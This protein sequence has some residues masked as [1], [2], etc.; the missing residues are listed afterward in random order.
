MKPSAPLAGLLLTAALAAP[1]AAV[2]L[3]YASLLSSEVPGASPGTGLTK[4]TIDTDLMT[5]RVEASFGGLLGPTTVAHIHCCTALPGLGTAGVAT[6]VPTFAGFP[7][8][9]TAGTYDNTFD[10]SLASSYNPNFV[11]AQGGVANAFSTLLG[12]FNAGTAYLNIHSSKF[13]GGEI[14]GFPTAVP[15]PETYALMVAG[16]A[17]VGWAAKRRRKQ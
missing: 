17:A 1:A 9:V 12:G 13:P 7:S 6:Q 15:E 14:R 4:L 5:M 2:E 3:V 10:M 8:G 16:L 11:T